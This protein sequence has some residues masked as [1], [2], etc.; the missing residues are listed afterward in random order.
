[1]GTMGQRG[2]RRRLAGPGA[3][4]IACQQDGVELCRRS[5]VHGLSREGSTQTEWSG[6]F[7]DAF[8]S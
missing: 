6:S 1:M 2:E 8:G 7:G 4:R 3:G 5:R